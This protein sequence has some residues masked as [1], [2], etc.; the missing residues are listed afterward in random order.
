MTAIAHPGMGFDGVQITSPTPGNSHLVIYY[1]TT[2]GGDDGYSLTL[3]AYTTRIIN[4]Q[5]Q[6]DDKPFP[7]SPAPTDPPADIAKAIA[8]HAIAT[9]TDLL[10][11]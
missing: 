1:D 5:H 2:W 11:L 3:R 10:N 8:R 4:H 6:L 9:L 7:D